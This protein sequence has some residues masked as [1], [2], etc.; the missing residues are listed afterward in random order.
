MAASL[1]EDV[2][3]KFGDQILLS[4]TSIVDR[5]SVVIPVS[6]ALDIILNGGIPE[7]S[8]IVFT[9]QP[10]CGKTTTSL[11]FAATAQKP[12]YQG[13]LKNPRQ[14]YYL[15]I[16]GRLKKRDLEGIPNLDLERFNVIGSQQGKILHAEE[17]LQIAER[18]INEEPGS[19]L[20]ID[21]YSALCTEAEITSSMDKMQR[22]DGAK[23]LAKFC[24]KVANVIPVNKNIVIGITHLMGNPGYG[25]VEWKEKSGQAIAYQTDVKLRAKMFKAWHSGADGPQIGQEVGWTVLCSALGPPGGNITSYIRY[26]IGVD[27]AMELITLCVDFGIIAK[28]GAWYTLTSIKDKPKFQ[29]TEKLRQYVFDNPKVYDKLMEELRETMGI[30]CKSKT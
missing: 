9:G 29:G 24:R 1:K 26:G 12:E 15:N 18:I 21:S 5:E 6:P 19:I 22:A 8:F 30:T 14:V 4:A 7:G 3:K 25:N 17:Y 13:D 16:E 27:K 28:G 11:D 23:L 2:R 10:K 20:I